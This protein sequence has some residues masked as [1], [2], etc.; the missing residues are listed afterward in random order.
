MIEP[1]TAAPRIRAVFSALMVVM[2]LASLD[3]TIVSTALPTIV[4]EFGGL[5]HLSWIVTSYMLATTVVTPLYGKLGDLFGRKLVL[6]VAIVLFLIGSALCGMSTSMT[7]LIIF[8]AVQ[9]LGGGGLMVTTMAVVGDIIP[10]KD[11]GRYQGL[12]GAV[13]GLSTVL[14]PLIGGFMVD[15]LSWRWIF[16]INLP[17][18]VAA[19]LVIG[20]VL[21][22]KAAIGKPVIDYAGAVLLAVFL[23]SLI[24]LT[25]LGGHTLAW[26]SSGGVGLAGLAAVALILFVVVE[27]NVPAPMFPMHLFRNR[28][29]TVCAIVSLVV[30]LAM[31]GSV[32]YLPLYMQ[33][34]K[35]LTPLSAGLHLTPMMAGVLVS[36]I[37]SGQ[38]ISRAGRYRLFPI[39]GTAIMTL[40]LWLLSRLSVETEVWTAAA[41]ALVLGSGLGMVMQVLVL[42]AQ[43]V[44]GYEDLGVATSGVTLFRS[45]GG[46]VGVSIFG[47]IF[48]VA[49]ASRLEGLGGGLPS[50]LDPAGI[51]LL[52]VGTRDLYHNAFTEALQPIFLTAAIVSATAFLLTLFLKEVPLRSSHRSE[53]VGSALAMPRDARS[54]D[55]L[56]RIVLELERRENRSSVLTDIAQ[57]AGLELAPNALWLFLN[58][59][60]QGAV[61]SDDPLPAE[62]LIAKALAARRDNGEIVLSEE[63]S[64]S[65]H[66]IVDLYRERFAKLLEQWEPNRHDEAREMLQRLAV[67]ILSEPPVIKTVH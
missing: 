15:H 64:T 22:R 43:N 5:E 35:G 20:A 10:P 59:G 1:A 41:Y 39:I 34:V 7:E 18:A 48:A 55:E 44:V 66:R 65:Y 37:V 11:R 8:R 23:T 6:Q 60:R 29:F 30:G 63:G 13:F 19:I 49:L 16:Y 4:A 17:L 38:I 53:D 57:T 3:Q 54:V 32:T 21:P 28:I 51:K 56:E 12:F 25:S 26:T 36:S 2:L 9:G 47:A 45:I 46:S 14:G 52:P 50:G 33:V 61:R 67:S 58:A 40:G 31:F 24:L 62:T 27:L 42:A